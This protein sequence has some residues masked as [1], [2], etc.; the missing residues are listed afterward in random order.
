MHKDIVEK[1]YMRRGSV[2]PKS[3]W[4]NNIKI[5]VKEKYGFTQLRSRNNGGLPEHINEHSDFIK[6]QECL[7]KISEC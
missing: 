5:D 3:R 2:R 7:D 4:E 6:T 1:T